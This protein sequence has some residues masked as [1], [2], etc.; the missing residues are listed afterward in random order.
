M[1]KTYQIEVD[2]AACA[3]KMEEA[4]RKTEGV[5]D[6]SISFMTQKMSVAFAEGAD[7]RKVMKAV[8]KACRKV[9]PDC[10]IEY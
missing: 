10:T 8:E 4:A 6:A 5:E 9:E 3:A 2:C 1:K 7:E